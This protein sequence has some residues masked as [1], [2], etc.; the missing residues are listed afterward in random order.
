MAEQSFFSELRQRRV[1]Q[2]AAVYIAVAWGATEIVV[3][4]V[5]QLFLPAWVSTLVVI[6]FMV[7]FPLAMF[8]A[9]TFD[10]TRDGIQRTTIESRRGKATIVLSFL[11][12]VAGST[13]LFFLIKPAEQSRGSADPDVPPHSVAVLP[14][15]DDGLKPADAY[16]TEGLS[17]ELRDQ[18]GR[19]GIRIAARSSSV[20]ARQQGLDPLAT[21]SRLR[22]ANVVE[23]SMRDQGNKLRI[24]VELI[25]GSSGLALWFKTFERG[26]NELLQV[27]QSIAEEVAR[28]VLDEDDPVVAEP[29][30]RDVNANELMLLAQH[31]ER[32]VR[33]RQVVDHDTLL[34]AIRLYREATEADPESALAHSRLA[35]ALLYLGDLDS[36]EAPIFRALSLNPDLSEVRNTLGE[37]YW[38]RGLPGAETE[39][40]RAV[41]LDPNNADALHN[42]GYSL[43]LSQSHSPAPV[44]DI[45]LL[46]RR[47]MDLDPL[48][49]SRRAALGEL[50]GQAGRIEEVREVIRGIRQLFDSVESY[51]AIGWLKE[52]IGEYDEAIAWTIRARELEPGNPDH[53]SKLAILFALIGDPETAE[54]LESGPSLGLLFQLRRYG[55]LVDDGELRMIDDPGDIEARFLLAL[56]YNATGQFAS[57]IRVLKSVGIPSTSIDQPVRSVLE[58]EASFTFVNALA[59]LA[60]PE[61]L[62]LARSLA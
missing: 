58:I 42:Y 15:V 14:F 34:E 50:L 22:V 5:E 44:K 53:V 28:I 39:F 48:S 9:W 52:L 30:T 1:F 11:L 62:E 59:G 27:Q 32:Q 49:V 21:A 24:Y 13:G 45:S 57:A 4:V 19:S 20:Q 55:D 6:I 7:G 10:L 35:G 40:A 2:A 38:L 31:Y 17:D 46:F 37:Y 43:W 25:E 26:P 36:A 3:T 60:E 61:S 29:A 12:L 47:A 33:D 18:L 23:G 41:Q 16:L 51:R 8:L 56:A 54:R